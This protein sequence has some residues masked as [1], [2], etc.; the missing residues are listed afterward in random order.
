MLV[1]VDVNATVRAGIDNLMLRAVNQSRLIVDADHDSLVIVQIAWIREEW[2]VS[3]VLRAAHAS[4]LFT[5]A[6]FL[7]GPLASFDA[8]IVYQSLVKMVVWER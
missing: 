6:A 4:H 1:F 8:I 7:V 5:L 3:I 2:V